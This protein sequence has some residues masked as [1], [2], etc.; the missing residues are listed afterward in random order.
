MILFPQIRNIILTFLVCTPALALGYEMGDSA[1]WCASFTPQYLFVNCART[2]VEKR[3]SHNNWIDLGEEF[4]FGNNLNWDNSAFG[5][6]STVVRY[7]TPIN[8]DDILGAGLVVSDKI[9]FGPRGVGYSGFYFN[10]GVG[11]SQENIG[12]QDNAWT[13]SYQQNGV[14]FYYYTVTKGTLNIIN[15]TEFMAFGLASEADGIFHFDINLGGAYQYAR[16][17]STGLPASD[18]NYNRNIFDYAYNGFFP[19]LTFQFAFA[20]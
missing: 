5:P 12:F 7:H 14:I 19:L 15:Y 2:D 1:S 6:T 3:L 10:Y 4:Y 8:N 18:R 13:T 16:V 9:F 17:S 11:Y 20:F